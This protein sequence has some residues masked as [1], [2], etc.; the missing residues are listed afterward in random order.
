MVPTETV[1][2]ESLRYTYLFY[3]QKAKKDQLINTNFDTIHFINLRCF[4]AYSHSVGRYYWR[5]YG[6]VL[7]PVVHNIIVH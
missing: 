6:L 2:C 4:D 1:G 3:E 5:T 7:L